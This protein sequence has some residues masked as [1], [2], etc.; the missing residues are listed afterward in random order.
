[1]NLKPAFG[2]GP[3]VETEQT[4]MPRLQVAHV[5]EQGV[6]LI[7]VPLNDQFEYNPPQ[8]QNSAV[9]EIQAR[10][11]SAGPRGT[12][13]PVWNNGGRMKFIAPRNW[14]PF[15]NGLSLNWV[16]ANLNRELY[17]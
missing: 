15:F 17:W 8:A 11:T 5:R 2:S 10:A 4:N 13:V 3:Q 7:I 16:A 14:H 9:H 1:V 6:D 12:V